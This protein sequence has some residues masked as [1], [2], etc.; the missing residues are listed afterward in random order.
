MALR[1]KTGN[2][3]EATIPTASM[4]DIAFLLLFFFLVTTTFSKDRGIKI[5]LPAESEETQ[6]RKKNIC[7]VW[8]NA[9]GLVAIEGMPVRMQDIEGEIRNRLRENEKLI[10]SLK[11]DTQASYQTMIDV[12][13]ELKLADAKRISLMSPE[14]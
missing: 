11:T 2:Q 6:V 12:M 5:V 1:R 10:I 14:G 13:D 8:I 7:H 4:A 3:G 9:E